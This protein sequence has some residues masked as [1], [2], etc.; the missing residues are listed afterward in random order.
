[1]DEYSMDHGI[2]TATRS[3]LNKYVCFFFHFDSHVHVVTDIVILFCSKQT[4]SAA[5]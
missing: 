2:K 4:N 5:M 3:F 1:L